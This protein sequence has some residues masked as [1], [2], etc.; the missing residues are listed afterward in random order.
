MGAESKAN[1]A[2]RSATIQAMHDRLTTA[3]PHTRHRLFDA[4]G[5]PIEVGGTYAYMP[6]GHLTLTCT[7]IREDLRPNAP[8]NRYIATFQTEV[9]MALFSNAP[10]LRLVLVQPP[11]TL[12]ELEKL[13]A[14][15]NGTALPGQ[16]SSSIIQLT[17]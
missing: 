15:G 1:A 17:D 2:A 7:D 10:T 9:P 8:P 16:P 6:A 3:I 14:E 5:R 13:G 4:Y 11:P 12:E